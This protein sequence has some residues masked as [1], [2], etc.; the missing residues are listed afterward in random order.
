MLNMLNKRVLIGVALLLH[1]AGAFVVHAQRM[2]SSWVTP[3]DLLKGLE[4][5]SQWLSYHGDYTGRRHSP[6][7]QITPQN[8]HQLTAQWTFQNDTPGK[9]EATP[10][11]Y[12]G[13]LY[14]TGPTIDAGWAVDARSGRQIWRYRRQ[15][16]SDVIVCCGLVN[17][18]FGMLGDRLFKA[19][20]DARIVALHAKTG[21][22]AW[23]VAMADYRKGYSATRAPL[24]VGN[25][26]IIGMAGAEYGVRGF[27]DAYDAESGARVW[28]FYT[29]AGPDDPGHNTWAGTDPNAWQYGGGS[30]WMTGTYDAEQNLVFWGTG[31]AGPDYDGRNREGDNLYTASL[32]AL[33]VET[34]TRRWHYQYTPHDTFDYDAVQ[35]PV[36]ADLTING[37]RRKVLMVAN[38]NGF[39]YT[40]ERTTGKVIVAKPIVHTTWAKGIDANGRPI[41][42]PDSTPTEEGT[43]VCPQVGPNW[44]SPS[45]DPSR[46]L[47]F[48]IVREG[49]GRFFR[50]AVEYRAGESFRGGMPQRNPGD[51]VENYMALRAIDPAT[52]EI[53]WEHRFTT[54]SGAGVLSTASGVLFTGSASS[55]VAIDSSRGQTL[56]S[57]QTGGNIGSAPITYMLDGRQYVV[58]A[59]GTTLTAFALPAAAPRGF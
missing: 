8:V 57:Y 38:R 52:A 45:Y 24:V 17:T 29:T 19:V 51:E 47:F 54:N 36:L 14:F 50:W 7:M 41:R 44:E 3:A 9:F 46:G 6:L 37:A 13:V 33:D 58:I 30:T 32:L 42:V 11:L 26:V 39:F 27:I 15:T 59:S 22:V 21:A 56:W 43:R 55:L 48:A 16:P 4:E 25:K 40:L 31:N 1:A 2:D 53:R 5:H 18:G 12:D 34:G 23:E 10:L 20:S 49:C 35:I 28:R